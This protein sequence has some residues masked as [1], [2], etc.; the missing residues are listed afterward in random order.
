M[1]ALHKLIEGTAHFAKFILAGDGQ[2]ASQITLALRNILHG[3]AHGRQGAQQHLDQQTQEHGD[4]ND[5]NQH[6]NQRGGAEL[7]QRCVG[8]V[9]IN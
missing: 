8:F 6:G 7:A 2:T 3:N 9:F 4:R 5:G 1:D